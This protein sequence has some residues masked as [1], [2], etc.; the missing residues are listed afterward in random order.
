MRHFVYDTLYHCKKVYD[1]MC[2]FIIF[3]E[4]RVYDTKVYDKKCTTDECQTK[5]AK[6]SLVP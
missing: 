4:N 1:T 2:H 6:F 5:S 3:F